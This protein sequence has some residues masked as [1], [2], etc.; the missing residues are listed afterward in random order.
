MSGFSKMRQISLIVEKLLTFRRLSSMQ[1]FG[2]LVRSYCVFYIFITPL[3][4]VMFHVF[5]EIDCKWEAC[6]V[7]FFV[8][9]FFLPSDGQTNDRNG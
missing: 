8:L 5:K 1:L 3:V 4:D 2:Q 7:A 6:A 9:Y